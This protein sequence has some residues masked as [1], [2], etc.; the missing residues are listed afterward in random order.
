MLL[1]LFVLFGVATVY[2]EMVK[3]NENEM[4]QLVSDEHN[5]KINNPNRR[6]IVHVRR[7]ENETR[8]E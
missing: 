7:L 6:L 8:A 5:A 2:A 1:L 3:L 4:P